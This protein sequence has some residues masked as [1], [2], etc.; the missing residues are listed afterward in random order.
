M[1]GCIHIFRLLVLV[2]L[3]HIAEFLSLFIDNLFSQMV[4]IHWKIL[5]LHYIT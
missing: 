5:Y 1:E 3:E 4:A 2:C